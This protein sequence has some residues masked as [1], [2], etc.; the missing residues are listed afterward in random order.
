MAGKIDARLK[1]LK[2]ELPNAAAPAANYVPFVRTGNLLFT[3]GQL[4]VWNGERRFVGKL[5]REYTVE[6]GQQAARLAGLNILAQVKAALDGDLDRI[7]RCVKLTG[8]VNSVPEFTEQPRVVNGASDLMVEVL[9]DAGRHART[10]VGVNV[11]PFDLT[12][13]IDAVFEVR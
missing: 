3:A 10:S 13:E 8:F 7:V 5:G 9:G 6:Q 11:L 12:V 2:I 1:E 4:C